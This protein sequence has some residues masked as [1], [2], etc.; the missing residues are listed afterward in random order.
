LTPNWQKIWPLTKTHAVF[1]L[2]PV[3]S[4]VKMIDFTRFLSLVPVPNEVKKSR[5]KFFL[6][7][8]PSLKSE[9][10]RP[11][12]FLKNFIYAFKTPVKKFRKKMV[13]IIY[14][15]YQI[16]ALPVHQNKQ[17]SSSF[18]FMPGHKIFL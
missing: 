1:Y 7:I 17:K 13:C 4:Q 14:P 16:R 10:L 18:N 2:V 8:Y 9:L 15:G 11:K 5:K 3:L 6:S 12:T